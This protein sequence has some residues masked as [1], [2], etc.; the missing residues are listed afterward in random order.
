MKTIYKVTS[1]KSIDLSSIATDTIGKI[2][3]EDALEVIREYQKKLYD[4]QERLYAE[5]KRSLL[6]ILQAMDTG[7]KD[8]AVEAIFSGINPAGI[9]VSNFK[10]PSPDELSHDF[11]WRIHKEVPPKGHIGIWNRSHYEDVLIVKVHNII[12]KKTCERRY[13]DIN[14][15]EKILT[16]NDVVIIKFF[17]HISK[18]EQKERLQSRLDNKDKHWKFNPAD[19]KERTLWNKYRSAYE[20]AIDNCSTDSAPWYVVPADH[21]WHRNIVM[22]ETIVKTLEKMD[23]KYPKTDLDPSKIIIT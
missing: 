19:I 4:L 14:A 5:H 20:A 6:I 15:F 2:K 18:A 11:L 23:P 21:K 7:G 17:L 9:K 10:A 22:I 1:N 16:G 13:E 3:K 8:G 12:D